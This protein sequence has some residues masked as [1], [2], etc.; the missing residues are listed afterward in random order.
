MFEEG[1]LLGGEVTTISNATQNQRHPNV[2]ELFNESQVF[3]PMYFAYGSNLSYS[4]MKLRCHNNPKKSAKPVAIARLDGWRWLISE[5]G[6]A[7]II[8]PKALRVGLQ[9]TKGENVPISGKEDAVFGILYDMTPKDESFL[10]AYEGVDYDAP[11]ASP[12]GKVDRKIRLKEQGYGCY[13]KWYVPAIVT[14]WLDGSEE[15]RRAAQSKEPTDTQTVLVYL[16][17]RHV[18]VGPPKNEYIARMN[19]AVRES[20]ELGFPSDWAESVIGRLVPIVRGPR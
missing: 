19:R 7:N 15:S 14:Q 6:Y 10:D 18:L 13:N 4:Q 1:N 11:D 16:D 8:P 5:K 3:R 20:V 17:E 12:D 2:S 9:E